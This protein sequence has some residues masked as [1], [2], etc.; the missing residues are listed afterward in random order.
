MANEFLNKTGLTYFYNRLKTIFA[1][2]SEASDLSDRIDALTT[3]GV[4]AN[5]IDSISVNGSPLSPDGSKGVSLTIPTSTSDL[6]NNGDGTVGS[7]FAT[8]SY[9]NTNGGK[10]DKIKVNDVEQSIV[11]KTVSLTIPVK[12]SDLTNDQDFQTEEEVAAAIEAA[13]SKAYTYKGSVDSASELPSSGNTAGDLYDV[14][15]A[16]QNYIWDGTQW[17]PAG[18]LID[19]TALWSKTELT[20]I[21]TAEIDN[22]VV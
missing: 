16:G 17:N 8:E 18:R 21:T 6:T 12:L 11:N 14:Q 22:I 9:V 1:S 7:K 5:K 15:E 19:T 3:A 20:P 2:K 4:E 10:I 13:V